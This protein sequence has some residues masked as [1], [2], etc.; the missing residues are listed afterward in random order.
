MGAEPV[1]R[2]V[3]ITAAGLSSRMEQGGKKELRLVDGIPVIRKCYHAFADCSC[4]DAIVITHP[5]EGKI[6]MQTALEEIAENVIWVAGGRS[7]QESVSNA[8]ERLAP[9]RPQFVLI[10]DGARPWVR[11]DLILAVLR[12]AEAHGA[13]VPVI[14]VTDAPKQLEPDGSISEH[15][16]KKVLAQAQTPQGFHFAKIREAHR[17]AREAGNDYSDDAEAYHRAIGSVFTVA[18]DP[19]NRKITFEIDLL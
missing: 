4:F 18:G 14:G 2:A 8:L 10:H 13:C 15:L 6:A 9:I 17:V 19:A 5:P 11:P 7:R 16:D 3:I 1:S 12:G